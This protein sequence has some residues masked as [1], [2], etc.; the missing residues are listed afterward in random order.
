MED[1][2]RKKGKRTSR[3]TPFLIA[4]PRWGDAMKLRHD[5]KTKKSDHD[6][7]K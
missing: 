6:D 3:T 5:Q 1:S 2:V 7:K 4:P